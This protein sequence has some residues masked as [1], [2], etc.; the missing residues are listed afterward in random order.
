MV[1]AA[2]LLTEHMGGHTDAATVPGLAL[3][4]VPVLRIKPG[5]LSFMA[6]ECSTWVW[7]G[8]KQAGRSKD[9]VL[10]N[11]SSKVQKGNRVN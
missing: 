6:P 4:V 10:G 3:A 5:G 1:A 7:I 2:V 9:N 8:R 11:S